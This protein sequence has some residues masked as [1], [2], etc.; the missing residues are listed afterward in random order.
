MKARLLALAL[1]LA[2]PAT[3]QSITTETLPSTE[4]F[5]GLN[6]PLGPRI[7]PDGEIIDEDAPVA[8]V[9][10]DPREPVLVA[11][12]A[13]LRGLDKVSGEVFD[14]E[15]RNGEM[16]R[17]GRLNVTLGDCRY[18]AEDPEGD[19]YTWLVVEDATR[20]STLFEG[21]M[22]ASSPAL[23]PLDHPRYDVWALR[24]ITS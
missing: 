1:I 11:K 17:V 22:V 19:A 4:Q 2:A 7:G 10:E 6:D 23:N 5:P 12:G 13:M 21:W 8:P 9:E 20:G 14:L 18:P 15:L 16:G 24:C 3:A